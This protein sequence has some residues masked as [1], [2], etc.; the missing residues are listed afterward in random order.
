VPALVKCAAESVHSMVTALADAYVEAF[1]LYRAPADSQAEKSLETSAKQMAAGSASAVRGQLMLRE[2]RTSEPLD[3]SGMGHIQREIE[4]AMNL[5]VRQGKLKLKRQRIKVFELIPAEP[6][7]LEDAN[8]KHSTQ[9]TPPPGVYGNPPNLID[10]TAQV[11]VSS[12]VPADSILALAELHDTRGVAAIDPSL[13]SAIEAI[14]AQT[15]LAAQAIG[16]YFGELQAYFA[17]MQTPFLESAVLGGTAAIHVPQGDVNAEPVKAVTLEIGKEQLELLRK[18]STSP[19]GLALSEKQFQEIRAHEWI[20][21]YHEWHRGHTGAA[22]Q[23]R[24]PPPRRGRRVKGETAALHK[25]WQDLGCP[26]V[27]AA[28][29]D[30]LAKIVCPKDLEASKRA[31][32]RKRLRD[33]IRGALVRTQRASAT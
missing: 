12:T 16:N 2:K 33:R 10:S 23:A 24:T 20:E 1:T 15:P 21:R 28:V 31:V 32:A 18:F 27:T 30:A 29:C 8:C 26:D 3:A 19:Q 13:V 6:E 7:F 4:T 25:A 14:G 9:V 22:S 5:A 17:E 11:V